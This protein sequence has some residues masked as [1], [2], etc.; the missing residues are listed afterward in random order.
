[1]TEKSIEN[2]ETSGLTAKG[3][4]RAKQRD[5][6]QIAELDEARA[7]DSGLLEEPNHLP[8]AHFLQP[9]AHLHTHPHDWYGCRSAFILRGVAEVCT[10]ASDAREIL[11]PSPQK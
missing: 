3:S 11:I 4:K 6:L 7:I 1:V 2:K 10:S 8:Q 9:F 5:H